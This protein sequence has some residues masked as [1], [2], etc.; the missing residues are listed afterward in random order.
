VAS[1]QSIVEG[2]VRELVR[3]PQL[4]PV[5]EPETTRLVDEVLLDYLDRAA[6]SALPPLEMPKPPRA[7][8]STRWPTSGRCRRT[9]TTPR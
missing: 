6:M 5:L 3:R 4:D 2:E 9:S 1:A 7:W 8:P